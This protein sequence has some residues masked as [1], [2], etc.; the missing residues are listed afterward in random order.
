MKTRRVVLLVLDGLGVGAMPDA[1]ASD[2][3]SHTLRHVI[4]RGGGLDVPNLVRLGLA[5]AA[6]VADLLRGDGALTGAHGLCRLG[7]PGADTYLGHQELM[8]A[9]IADVELHMLAD[10]RARIVERLRSDGHTVEDVS[11]GTTAL[12]VDGRAVVADNIEAAPGLNINITGSLDEIGFQELEAIGR[13]IREEVA[14]PR[15]IV[16]G[17]RGF[18]VADILAAMRERAPGHAGVDTPGLGTYD[19]NYVVRHLGFA[20]SAIQSLPQLVAGAGGQVVLLGKAADVV[21]YEGARRS[22]DIATDDVLT[23]TVN[24]LTPGFHG[25]IVANIQET[26][27]AGHEQDARRFRRVLE[28]VDRWIPRILEQ[29][30]SDGV[31]FIAADHGNDPALGTSRHT[32]EYVP[33]LVAGEGV[34]AVKIGLRSS[35]GDIAATVADLLG[36]GHLD[37]GVSFAIELDATRAASGLAASPSVPSMMS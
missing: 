28:N 11:S 27:L 37:S 25:L 16:V 36:A 33:V 26:D 10:R 29:L 23:N 4:E 6:G 18:R 14:L 22:N 30:G 31:L 20:H 32:R 19:E 15:V 7:Y 13:S 2:I 17:G 35:L 8:G 1:P 34:A 3:G 9:P 21:E 24:T 12:L 5:D